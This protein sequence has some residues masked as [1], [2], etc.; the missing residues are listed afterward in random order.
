MKQWIDAETNNDQMELDSGKPKLQ[1]E[2]Y[3][4]VWGKLKAF[5]NK[6]HVGAH[7][8]RPITDYNEINYH[9]L[10]ATAVHLMLTRG[11]PQSAANSKIKSE[12]N[13]DYKPEIGVNGKPIP[14]MSP[15]A[16]KA[17]NLFADSAQSNEGLHLQMLA[18]QLGVNVHQAAQAAE[19]LA[20]LSLIY[21]T[22]DEETWAA[23]S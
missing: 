7:V 15:M 23:L 19:E 12:T 2:G 21:T 14:Q 16:R 4:R 3:C 6:K 17:Y 1:E 18:S 8:L 22:V 9:L 13:G 5:N 20:G 11:P 10:E